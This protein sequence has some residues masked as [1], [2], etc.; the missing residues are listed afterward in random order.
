LLVSSQAFSFSQPEQV[1]NM[2]I[3]YQHIGEALWQRDAPRSIGS[4]IDGV[5]R[6]SLNEIER[7]LDTINP[8]EQQAIR[9][10]INDLAPSGF[11][12]WGIPSGARQILKDMSQG[13]FLLLLESTDFRYVGQVLFR[14]SEPLHRLSAHIWGE[15][16]FPIIILLQGEMITYGWDRFREHFGF[17]EAYHM[18]GNTARIADQRVSESPSESEE[19]FIASILTTTGRHYDDQET[20]FRAFANN[21][22]FHMRAVKARL[23]QQK[24]RKR[25]LERQGAT[26]AVCDIAVAG[27]IEA[28]HV[29]PKEHDGSDDERNG[30]ALCATHHRMFDAGVFLVNPYNLSIH[31]PDPG[32]TASDLRITRLDLGHL[33]ATP[34]RQAFNWRWSHHGGANE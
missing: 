26:C 12:I 1:G 6:F 2:T 10:I 32:Y 27:V 21:L 28:A 7:F 4:S 31:I 30:L 25:V 20:D 11:Q 22:V 17:D 16:R 19:A 34:H 24:F 5:R 15:E 8:F 9:Q 18:R 29:V 33:T 3:Y 13:D 14:I 23:G